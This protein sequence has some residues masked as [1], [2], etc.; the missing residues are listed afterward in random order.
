MLEN[1]WPDSKTFWREKQVIVTGGAG[2]SSIEL[3]GSRF[4]RR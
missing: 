2:G 3:L 4:S 1:G